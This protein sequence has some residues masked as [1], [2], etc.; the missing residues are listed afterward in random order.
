MR[1]VGLLITVCLGLTLVGGCKN[2]GRTLRPARADQDSSISSPPPP[3]TGS[4]DPTFDDPDLTFITLPPAT[5]GY[6]A[7]APWRDGQAIDARYTCEGINLAPA[8][9][10]SAA[11]AGT[12]EVAVTLRDLDAPSFVHWVIAG[13]AP[14]TIALDEATV[15]VGAYEA[16]N[17]NGDLG[18][19]GPCPP[20]G[21]T[22]TYSI[23][24]HYLGTLTGL[25][26]GTPGAALIDLITATETASVEVTGTFGRP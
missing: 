9:S 11:P 6:I 13:L 16:S 26:D 18:Y 23:T 15:P 25:D 1:R 17:G 2:D 5:G 14:E 12:V 24:V 20:A 21:T 10:W 19:T 3:T 7:T 8:L 4:D 22:H